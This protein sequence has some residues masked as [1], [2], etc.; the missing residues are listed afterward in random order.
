[1]LNE[2]HKSSPNLDEP[3]PKRIIDGK[4]LLNVQESYWLGPNLDEPKPKRIIDGKS[5]LNVQESY[6][7]GPGG[8]TLF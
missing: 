1:L 8:L 7:L 6:W 3:K 2:L 4:S 5:L